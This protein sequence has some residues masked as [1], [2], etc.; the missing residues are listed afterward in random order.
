MH[1]IR[2][3]HLSLLQC[4]CM[5][6][7]ARTQGWGA[8]LQTGRTAGLP[9]RAGRSGRFWPICRPCNIPCLVCTELR[10]NKKECVCK[11]IK[12]ERRRAG[13]EERV[14]KSERK[15]C[16]QSGVHMTVDTQHDWIN[17]KELGALMRKSNERKNKR[18]LCKQLRGLCTVRYS[19]VR[20]APSLLSCLVV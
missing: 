12:S 10:G 19:T 1:S 6:L 2:Y 14:C 5:P 9:Y 13:S 4:C 7:K 3:A 16:Y 8:R 11:K 20:Y 15:W 17:L 18:G